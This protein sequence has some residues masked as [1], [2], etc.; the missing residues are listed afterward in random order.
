VVDAASLFLNLE[1]HTVHAAATLEEAL[2]T[3]KKEPQLDLLVTDYHLGDEVTGLQV[4]EGVRRQVGRT[5]PSILVTGD[6]SS[7]VE[8]QTAGLES[9][10]T[11][12]KPVDPDALLERIRELLA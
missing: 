3:A 4:I 6:T 7:S 5:V 10:G 1:G 12:N 8:E 11:L 2:E 9:C